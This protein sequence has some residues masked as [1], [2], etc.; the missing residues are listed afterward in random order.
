[1]R[2]GLTYARIPDHPSPATVGGFFHEGGV[3]KPK[4]LIK[5]GDRTWACRTRR[6]AR[7]IIGRRTRRGG[8]PHRLG[9]WELLGTITIRVPK[10]VSRKRPSA[11]PRHR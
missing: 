7:R 1:M 10:I 8:H 6:H 3:M 2:W 11:P 9:R 5:D 4:Y